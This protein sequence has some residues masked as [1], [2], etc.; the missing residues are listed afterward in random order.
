MICGLI[1]HPFGLVFGRERELLAMTSDISST[2]AAS[3]KRGSQ[4]FVK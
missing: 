2:T 3:F 4:N 1:S